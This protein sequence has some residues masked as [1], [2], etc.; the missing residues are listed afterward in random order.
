MLYKEGSY[1]FVEY[2]IDIPRRRFGYIK[3]V[4]EGDCDGIY[5]VM[6]TRPN[7]SNW[8]HFFWEDEIIM[9]VA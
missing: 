6:F 5:E 1:V 2:G 3:R 8:T 7:Y 4:W 9:E